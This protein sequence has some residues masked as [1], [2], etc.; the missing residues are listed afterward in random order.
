MAVTSLELLKN[1][2]KDTG[3]FR[4]GILSL[5]VVTLKNAA[6]VW[7]GSAVFS[8]L[9]M[10]DIGTPVVEAHLG[11]V[12]GGVGSFIVFNFFRPLLTRFFTS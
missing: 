2:K 7:T 6:E 4:A 10:G 1:H 9:H 3:L 8:G 5:A 11:G 12:I